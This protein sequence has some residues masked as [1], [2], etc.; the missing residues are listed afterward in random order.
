M[1]EG[2]IGAGVG[3][4]TF[5]YAAGIGTSSRVVGEH[6]VGVLVLA[7]FG[8]TEHFV[9]CGQPVGRAL[10]RETASSGEGSCLCLVATDAPL[11]PHQLRRLAR[12]PFVGPGAHGL[13]RLPRLGRDRLRLD[14]R[15]PAPARR[16]R[17]SSRC[18]CCA[19]TRSACSSPRAPRPPR[20]P[21]STRSAPGASCAGT[22]AASLPRFP[23]ERFAARVTR[24]PAAR[25][26]ARA[27]RIAVIGGAGGMGR[28]TTADAAA[29]DGVERVLLVDRDEERAAEVAAAHENVEVR[30]A[31]RERGG[32][33]RGAG[34]RR[35]GRQRRLAP[36]QPA[37]HAGLPRGRR[38]LHRP[39]RPLLLRDRAVR[40]R[41]GL[42]RGR[43]LGRDLDGRGARHHQHARG[44]GR[45]RARDGRVDRGARRRRRRAGR[46][47]RTSP[48]CPPTPPTR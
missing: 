45:R 30:R 2:Q 8:L 14:D 29:S 16:R 3:M 34:R 37:G 17:T 7:N 15:E 19:T 35:R 1:A 27:M 42:P 38:A 39:R 22:T 4:E 46:T 20:R 21:S 18:G 10:A 48:T 33:A 9:L 41:R 32:H 47:T 40:A 26:Y 28:I 6:T 24:G 44:G 13:V 11:L 5:G 36:A 25:R 31:G 12:R 23:A 43:A